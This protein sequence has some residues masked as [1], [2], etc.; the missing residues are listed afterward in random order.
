MRRGPSHTAASAARRMPSVP[1]AH[2]RQAQQ[3]ERERRHRSVEVVHRRRKQP[4]DEAK[5]ERDARRRRTHARREDLQ[6]APGGAIWQRT[7]RKADS[8]AIMDIRGYYTVLQGTRGRSAEV[9]NR[10]TEGRVTLGPTGRATDLSGQHILEH[11]CAA[12]ADTRTRSMAHRNRPQLRPS[13]RTLH[14]STHTE[15]RVAS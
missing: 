12:Q 6:H 7:H 10:L 1:W 2:R 14:D 15:Q 4:A 5:H 9:R 13:C 11:V 3:R 8:R